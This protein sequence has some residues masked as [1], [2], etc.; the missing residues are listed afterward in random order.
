MA[1]NHTVYLNLHKEQGR[2]AVADLP[3]EFFRLSAIISAGGL[4]VSE[5][6]PG[7]HGAQE[8]RRLRASI[9]DKAG[10]WAAPRELLAEAERLA[11]GAPSPQGVPEPLRPSRFCGGRT[12]GTSGRAGICDGDVDGRPMDAIGCQSSLG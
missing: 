10:G 5:P 6:C 4:V 11:R 12:R 8:H 2:P 1:A 7:R 3:A 9:Y